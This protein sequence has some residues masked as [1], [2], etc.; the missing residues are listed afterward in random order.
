VTA[1]STLLTSADTFRVKT[2]AMPICIYRHR[3]VVTTTGTAGH[4]ETIR[5]LSQVAGVIQAGTDIIMQTSATTTT[6]PRHVEWFGFGKGEELYV[7]IAG[8]TSTTMPYA[9]TLETIGV[10]PTAVPGVYAPGTITI[11]TEGQAHT[12]D[13]DFWVYDSNLNAIPNFGNDDTPIGFPGAGV[14]FE[15][16][17][18][19]VYT[20]GTYF[21][22]MTNYQCGNDQPAAPNDF[23]TGN[24]VD[25]P[26]LIVNGPV[27]TT[28]PLDM[29]FQ[30]NDGVTFTTVP[31]TKT[32]RYEIVWFQFTVGA[33]TAPVAYCFGDGTSTACPC[34]IGVGCPCP[35]T[36]GAG[37][38]CPWSGNPLGANLAGNGNPS[39]SADSIVL[40][41]SGMPNSSALYFQGTTRQALGAGVVFGDGLRC[42][43][44]T[45]IRLGTKTN[46]SGQSLYPDVGDAS[47]SVKGLITA[48]GCIRTYQ[49]WYRNAADFCTASTFNLTN[50][51]EVTWIP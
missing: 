8:T 28:V 27:T 41:G 1:G 3:L 40:T 38:G 21:L 14:N 22:A 19:E 23:Q 15:G 43:G 39:I 2:C 18:V 50:G 45:V 24:V 20:P 29:T 25:F 9:A 33:P 32:E 4:T 47:I 46:S 31:C 11:T 49:C 16:T 51:V 37:N 13:T 12:T 7:R 5:G 44:G 42:A 35:S 48:G 17:L 26:N 6:P 10:T 36:G 34:N 30:I